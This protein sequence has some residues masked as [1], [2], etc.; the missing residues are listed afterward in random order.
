MLENEG[1]MDALK[2]LENVDRA[3]FQNLS[4]QFDGLDIDLQEPIV[5]EFQ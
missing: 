3:A 5:V 4:D 1:G 2:Q